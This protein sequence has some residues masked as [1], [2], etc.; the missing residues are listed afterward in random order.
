M[1]IVVKANGGLGNRMR[2]LAS[3]IALSQR[4]RQKVEVIWI[5]NKELNCSF[6]SLFFEVDNIIIREEK[7]IPRWNKLGHRLRR[8]KINEYSKSFDIQLNDDSIRKLGMLKSDLVKLIKNVDTVFINTCEHF[9]GDLSFVSFLLPKEHI[10]N[11]CSNRLENMSSKFISAHIRRG[12][13]LAST[14]HSPTQLFID[15]LAI[16]LENNSASYIYLATDDF[17]EAALIKRKFGDNVFFYPA[18]LKRDK[19]EGIQQALVDLIMLSQS[20]KIIGSYWSSFTEVAA[21]YGSI[22]LMTVKKE[23]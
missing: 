5:N 23:H 13:N 18:L 15:N 2:V 9:Y 12:D 22:P 1:K 14:I 11:V 16:E 10:L 17:E 7:Y 20:N 4:L 21:A 3:C 6:D 19:P 8:S